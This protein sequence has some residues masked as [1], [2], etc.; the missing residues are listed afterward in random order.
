MQ[1]GRR[2][3]RMKEQ[4][5]NRLQNSSIQRNDIT[6]R[7]HLMVFCFHT[8]S[9][10]CVKEKELCFS[11]LW[12]PLFSLCCHSQAS[13]LLDRSSSSSSTSLPICGL[14]YSTRNWT[15]SSLFPVVHRFQVVCVCVLTAACCHF[16]IP[17]RIVR[18]RSPYSAAFDTNWHTDE[19][20]NDRSVFCTIINLL[21]S[22]HSS[23]CIMAA[24]GKNAFIDSAHQLKISHTHQHNMNLLH[25]STFPL[26][27]TLTAMTMIYLPVARS[28]IAI[29]LSWTKG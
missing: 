13:H 5:K 17:F 2:N 1:Y 9:C 27:D 19:I 18:A 4:H 8:F 14:S 6:W 15:V 25:V 21:F 29:S 16:L 3:E 24:Q 11:V 22:L 20:I 10:A 23:S 28:E 12:L 7:D 26:F